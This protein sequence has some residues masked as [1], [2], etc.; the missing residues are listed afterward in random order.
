M[1]D[2]KQLLPRICDDR[3][4]G[5]NPPIGDLTSLCVYY[6]PSYAEYGKCPPGYTES[7]VG[8]VCY[9]EIRGQPW[10]EF[11]LNTGGSS[12]SFLDL[13]SNE[14]YS[15]LQALSESTRNI[16]LPAKNQEPSKRISLDID[17]KTEDIELQWLVGKNRS[18]GKIY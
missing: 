1:Y 16:G 14:Q 11:C 10:E 7:V 5:W 15:I 6:Q 13:K 9:Q 12:L 3:I 17:Y 2:L 8:D 18:D 4:S